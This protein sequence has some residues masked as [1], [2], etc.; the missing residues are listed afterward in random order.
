MG[1]H[2]PELPPPVNSSRD[3]AGHRRQQ[4]IVA[5]DREPSSA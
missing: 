2:Q 4:Q 3:M 1:V 5:D